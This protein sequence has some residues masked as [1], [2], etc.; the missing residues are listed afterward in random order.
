MAMS[1]ISGKLRE[2]QRVCEG[3]GEAVP[4]T[5]VEVVG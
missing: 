3:G 5:I 1:S 4:T 2:V